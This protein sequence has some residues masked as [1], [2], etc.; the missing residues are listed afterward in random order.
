MDTIGTLLTH[1]RNGYKARKNTVYSVYSRVL[2]SIVSML[3]Q[4]GII[5]DFEIV[6]VR[7]NIKRIDIHLRDDMK[8][9]ITIRR[10]SKPGRRVYIKARD[11]RSI[12]KGYGFWIISTPKGIMDNYMAK[13]SN[14]GGE[15]LCEII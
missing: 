6:E 7:P 11:I 3:K 14:L 5:G 12:A 9:D 2:E 8:S 1:I 10:I 13:K 4:K 15:V